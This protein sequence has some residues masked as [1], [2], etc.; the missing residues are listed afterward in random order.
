MKKKKP[1]RPYNARELSAFCLQISLLLDAGMPI[2]STMDI[3]AEDAATENDREN[4]ALIADAVAGGTP[5]DAALAGAGLFPRYVVQMAKVGTETGTLDVCMRRLSEH[6]GHEDALEQT[7]RS[8][9]AY[10]MTMAL[11]LLAVLFVLLTRV[12]PVFERVYEQKGASLSATAEGA[13]R[14]GTVLT[15]VCFAFL[16]LAAA[17]FLA[18]RILGAKGTN[19]LYRKVQAAIRRKSAVARYTAVRRFAEVLA[20]GLRSGLDMSEGFTLAADVIVR[21]DIRDSARKGAEALDS[22]QDFMDVLRGMNVFSKRQMQMIAV[23]NR[24][25]RLD[26]VMERIAKDSAEAAETAIETAVGRLEPTLV[27]VMSASVGLIL[28]AVMLPLVGMLAAIG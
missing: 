15:V 1:P 21:E 24:S 14:A 18:Y 25:G 10:P 4:L 7:V 19:P 28:L 6:Y 20:L 9:V 16:L 26:E 27:A 17:L 5:F 2:D 12:F 8:A 23:G 13:V 11:M 22:G 3:L